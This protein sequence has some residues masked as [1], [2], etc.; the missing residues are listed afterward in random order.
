MVANLN[1]TYL[2]VGICLSNVAYAPVISILRKVYVY[3]P[4]EEGDGEDDEY[5]RLDGGVYE[6]VQGDA[7]KSYGAMDLNGQ[8]V[9][10]ERDYGYGKG[11]F[12]YEGGFG[13]PDPRKANR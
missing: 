12:Q 11:D 10:Q 6:T 1:F 5:G 7:S 13:V 4:F 9:A 3:K 8:A 2:N